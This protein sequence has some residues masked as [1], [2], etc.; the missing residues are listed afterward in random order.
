MLRQ[1]CKI[2][3]GFDPFYGIGGGLGGAADPFAPILGPGLGGALGAPPPGFFYDPFWTPGVGSS[4]RR[5]NAPPGGEAGA[6]AG[7][8]GDE[9]RA[10]A[11][12]VAVTGV[13]GGETGGRPTREPYTVVSLAHC[14]D[15]SRDARAVNE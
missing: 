2:P 4:R 10:G 13:P 14:P 15:K 5:L 12:T 9:R 3:A 8:G 11:G 1:K 6:R 7:G